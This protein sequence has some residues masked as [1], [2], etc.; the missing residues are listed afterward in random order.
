[1]QIANKGF[2]D[3]KLETSGSYQRLLKDSRGQIYDANGVPLVAN[4]AVQTIN[5]T[6]SNTMTAEEMRQSCD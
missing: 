4:Q 3:K 6:R 1:M 2:Y 5:F